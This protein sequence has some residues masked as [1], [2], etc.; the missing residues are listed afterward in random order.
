M[1]TERQRRTTANRKPG[2]ETGVAVLGGQRVIPAAALQGEIG[3]SMMECRDM[4]NKLKMVKHLK[5]TENSLLRAVA[6]RMVGG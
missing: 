6:E 4:N 2:M 5:N 1:D 3:T